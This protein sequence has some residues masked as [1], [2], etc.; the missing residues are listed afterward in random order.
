M[1]VF[2]SGVPGAFVFTPRQIRDERG[3]FFEALRCDRVEAVTGRP[4]RPEQINYSVS[5]RN[6]LR[7]IHGVSVPPGQAKYVTCV[8]GALRDVVVDLRVGSPTFGRHH[9]TLLDAGSGRSVYVPEGVGHGFL[10]LTD[11]ACIC[12]VVSTR[13]VPGTQ[14]DINPLDSDLALPWGFTEPPLMSEKDAQAQGMR[15][16]LAA[17]LL[18]KWR[19]AAP[20]HTDGKH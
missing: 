4:F 7:G 1:D 6:T 14:I 12:Y 3:A 19:D 20:D 13:Y 16:A 8:R 11:D 2:E 5:R 9:V 15:E 18:A 10:T 17:G